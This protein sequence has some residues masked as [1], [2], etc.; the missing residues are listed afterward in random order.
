MASNY[1]NWNNFQVPGSGGMPDYGNFTQ[2]GN[3]N[4]NSYG[5][6]TG[7][8]NN[9]FDFSGAGGSSQYGCGG[10]NNLFDVNSFGGSGNFMSSYAQIDTSGFSGGLGQSTYDPTYSSLFAGAEQVGVSSYQSLNAQYGVGGLLASLGVSG[11]PSAGPPPL[12]NYVPPPPSKS[13]PPPAGGPPPASGPPPAGGTPPS[14]SPP[15]PAGSPPSGSPPPAG[16]PPPAKGPTPP[17]PPAAA[18]GEKVSID[19][20]GPN[21][22]IMTNHGKEPIKVAIMTNPTDSNPVVEPKVITI[23]P[24]DTVNLSFPTG[25]AGRINKT[26]G[27][28]SKS[29]LNEVTFDGSGGQMF[30]DQSVIDGYNGPVTMTPTNA[31]DSG[32][33]LP[34][35]VGSE[36]D[37]TQSAP[38]SMKIHNAD[39]TTSLEGVK[40][41]GDFA[42]LKD[43]QQYYLNSLGEGTAYT[44]P[45]DDVKSTR[46]VK[47]NSINI[48]FY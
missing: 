27:D 29:T 28:G 13:T 23:N 26:T 7:W 3:S 30:Y 8:G 40:P 31:K 12:G 9:L 45:K 35:T 16:G 4:S 37:I 14:G 34:V 46:I 25:W 39:G 6:L 42:T 15:P 36:K 1:M 24:G 41:V 33:G 5:S 20:G 10:F 48:D 22:S 32:N 19:G 2:G 47:D 44:Y 38:D 21:A 18:N 11:G 43:N 17:P